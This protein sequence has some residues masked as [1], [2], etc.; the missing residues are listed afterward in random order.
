M[1]ESEPYEL[2][3]SRRA[4]RYLERLDRDRQERIAQ[5]LRGLCVDPFRPGLTKPLKG[6]P[7]ERAARVGGLRV[8]FFVNAGERRVEVDDIAPR[9]QVYR[10][11]D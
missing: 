5:V 9:G 11:L 7:G 1:P 10:R 4:A 6:F 3:F 2:Q 8:V